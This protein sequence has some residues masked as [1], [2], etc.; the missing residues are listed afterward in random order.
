[1]PTRR[2]KL[3][4]IYMD[5]KEGN[6]RS[7]TAKR[8]NVFNHCT[9]LGGAFKI[10][11]NPAEPCANHMQGMCQTSTMHRTKRTINLL[12]HQVT[13]GGVSGRSSVYDGLS[14]KP[15]QAFSQEPQPEA[16]EIEVS[17]SRYKNCGIE[18]FNINAV[19]KIADQSTEWNIITPT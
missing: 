17:L 6:D 2:K 12:Q 5:G 19:P 10:D 13:M 8:G 1:M 3:S 11:G 16:A 4:V 15:H 14:R 9:S 18:G 7:E